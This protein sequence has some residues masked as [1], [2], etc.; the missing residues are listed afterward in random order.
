MKIPKERVVWLGEEAL[1]RL[2][3]SPLTEQQ[4]FLLTECVEAYLPLDETQRLDFD[5]IL[6]DVGNEKVKAMN[7]TTFEKGIETGIQN[8]LLDLGSKR[9]GPPINDIERRIQ[10]IQDVKKLQALTVRIL[11]AQSWDDLLKTS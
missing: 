9:F 8:V 7:K 10:A 5:R 1:K 11:D 3:D 6:H 4:K 2:T